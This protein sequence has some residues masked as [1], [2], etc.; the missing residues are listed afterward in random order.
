VGQQSDA[1]L[2]VVSTVVLA[3]L[4]QGSAF[5]LRDLHFFC[6]FVVVVLFRDRVS[7]YSLGCP[8]IHFVD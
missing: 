7:L 8:G 2:N 4:W 5:V 6:W 1:R 3:G